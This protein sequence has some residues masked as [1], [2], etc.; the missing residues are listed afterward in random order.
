MPQSQ[1]SVGLAR[2][3]FVPIMGKG[4]RYQAPGAAQEPSVLQVGQRGQVMGRGRGQVPQ[5][6][7][8][9]TQGSVYTITP[10]TEIAGQSVI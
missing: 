4:N 7:T 8:S 9:G 10:Q 2:A 1:S 3:Q 5:A 6:K